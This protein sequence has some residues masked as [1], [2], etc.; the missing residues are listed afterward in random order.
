MKNLKLIY[1]IPTLMVLVWGCGPR[2]QP[3]TGTE[4]QERQEET[5]LV[6]NC[7]AISPADAQTLFNSTADHKVSL[8]ISPL[9]TSQVLKNLTPLLTSDENGTD[10]LNMQTIFGISGFQPQ[11]AE[12][13]YFASR[14]L[15]VIAIDVIQGSNNQ[16]FYVNGQ[17]SMFSPGYIYQTGDVDAVIAIIKYPD[18]Q[19]G[20]QYIFSVNQLNAC[21]TLTPT[22]T[23][24]P[25]ALLQQSEYQN[26]LNRF[27][28]PY[29]FGQHDSTKSINHVDIVVP[30][31]IGYVLEDMTYDLE[32]DSS[33]NYK[34]TI[35]A[36]EKNNAANDKMLLYTYTGNL[37]TQFNLNRPLIE[38]EVIINLAGGGVKKVKII[39]QATDDKRK[40]RKNIGIDTLNTQ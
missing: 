17:S 4:V 21:M 31:N 24:N 36:S 35:N 13:K 29:I 16:D 10:F 22:S 20:N 38:I 25:F 19:Q 2:T 8:S 23:G 14:K 11:S 27:G 5:L 12:L 9:S 28:E 7:P 1:L 37:K 3:E 15:M 6:A 18:S 40:E 34:I 26:T 33:G 30:V 32:Q 39:T